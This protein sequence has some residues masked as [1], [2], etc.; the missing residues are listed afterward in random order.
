[1]EM[2]ALSRRGEGGSID[3]ARVFRRL[4][5]GLP[6]ALALVELIL[7]VRSSQF[8]IDFRG[9]IWGAGRSILAG[10]NPYPPAVPGLILH[11][12]NAFVNS[13]LLGELG[14][15]FSLL[16][17]T[18]SVIVFDLVCLAA[19]LA[20]LRTVGVDD[21]RVYL[22]CVSSFP[23]VSSVVLGQPDAIFALL[24]ALA[25]RYRGSW[26]GAFAAGAL[27]AAKFL[28]WPLVIW[29][30]LTRR[31]RQAAICAVSA[32]ALLA[33]GW[34]GLGFK[35]FLKFSR[36]LRADAIAFGGKSHSLVA[37]FISWGLSERV[38]LVLAIGGACLIATAIARIGQRTDL[39]L[40]S[41]AITLGLLCSPIVW[42]HY[43]LV[44]LVP[45]AIATCNRFDPI[46]WALVAALWLSPTETPH[47]T[48]QLWLIPILICAIAARAA[49]LSALGQQEHHSSNPGTQ[50][51]LADGR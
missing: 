32:P 28:A 27:I 17:T 49:F 3:W 25:W 15:P 41:A 16:A 5:L 48:W 9:A 30:L 4:A 43:L 2:W 13:P 11:R 8:G 35:G 40:F 36:V 47:A 42:Q 46:G 12:S 19:L 10:Q 1:M 34:A 18:P 51:V 26:R 24:A 38:A 20:A 31:F 14:I 22:L 44:L 45:M 50:W 33:F 29:F 21:W 37:L 7:Q 6:A 23:F 39:A